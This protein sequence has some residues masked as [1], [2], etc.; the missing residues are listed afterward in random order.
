[1][2]RTWK[3]ITV[4]FQT[5]KQQQSA[6]KQLSTIVIPDCDELSLDDPA[7]VDSLIHNLLHDLGDSVWDYPSLLS[8]LD[9]PSTSYIVRYQMQTMNNEVMIDCL[10]EIY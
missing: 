6:S 5:L 9:S 2:I 4:L 7:S 10:M 1:M 3:D 8:F